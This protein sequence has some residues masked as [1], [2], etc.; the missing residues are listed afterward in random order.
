MSGLY[1]SLTMA[2]RA[3]NAQQMGL[4]VTGNN[5]A[6][7]NTAG[8]SRR[9]IDFAAVPPDSSLSAGNGVDVQGVR[10]VRD[11][12]LERRVYDEVPTEGRSKEL[13]EI[14]QIV[15]SGI[16]TTGNSIDG[17]LTEMFGSFSRLADTPTSSVARGDVLNT[18]SELTQSFH[19]MADR[20]AGAQ[21]Q[22]DTRVRGSVEEINSLAEQIARLNRL[23]SASGPE[24][25]LPLQDQMSNLLR[26]LNAIVDVDAVEG[27]QGNVDV[28]IGNGRALVIGDR[29][30]QVSAVSQPPNGLASV[31]AGGADI[32]SELRGGRIAGAIE[33]RD[34]NIPDYMTRLDTVAYEMVNQVNALHRTGFDQLENTNQNFFTPLASATGA[35]RLIEVDPAVAADG[36]R[37]AAAGVNEAGDNAVAKSLTNLRDARVL[38][39]NSATLVDG[40]S[41]LAYRVGRDSRAAQDGLEAQS[42]IVAQIDALR[43]SVSGVSL[44]EEAVQMIKFQRAYEANARYFSTINDTLSILFSVVGR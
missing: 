12:L 24:G 28:T 21:R 10:A 9:A 30:Y 15:E 16:G 22:A 4:Q 38:E 18:A 27:P 20:L 35:A 42:A 8:Y 3:L 34:V 33:A 37:I 6:N 5:I 23:M 2:A 25:R 1:T 31:E 13:T 29:T 19:E 11:R 36:R 26:D 7:V 44:D 32:T 43:D 39:G 14:L 17:R 40:W 41:H